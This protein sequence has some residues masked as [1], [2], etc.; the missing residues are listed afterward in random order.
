MGDTAPAQIM[1]K[2]SA[3]IAFV[4]DQMLG[5]RA[6]PSPRR[7][8]SHGFQGGLS[9]PHFC[10]LST[11]QM[12]A[13]RHPS[14]LCDQH[15]LC[16]LAAAG[17]SDS[18]APFL[19]GTKLPSRKACAQSNFCC[20]SKEFRITPHSVSQT[21]DSSHSFRRRQQVLPGVYSRGTSCQ[22]APVRSTHSIPSKVLR[23][24]A[25]GLPM[26][27]LGGKCGSINCHCASL[28]SRHMPES[29]LNPQHTPSR[30]LR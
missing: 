8:Y 27:F 21:P 23:S 20:A 12:Q 1:P 14:A 2:A 18:S 19:A 6:R 17:Q 5:T 30:L 10:L 24:S 13:R 22:R 25:R 4:S 3:V 7:L 11:V 29:F 15:E 9:Q 16:A 28:S 26:R